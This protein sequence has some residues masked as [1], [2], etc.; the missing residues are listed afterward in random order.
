MLKFVTILFIAGI[1]VLSANSQ[2]PKAP[3]YSKKSSWL[4]LEK[5]PQ[6]AFD[7]FY[8]HPTTYKDLKDGKNASIDNVKANQ[9][10]QDAFNRQATAFKK[11]CNI[12]AP[13]YRQVSRK[14]LGGFGLEIANKCLEYAT[15]DMHKAFEYYL[16][17]YNNGRPF[18]L[19]SHSQGTGVTMEFL[20]KYGSIVDK[21][22]LVAA[23]LIG[24]AITPED[25]KQMGLKLAVTPEQLCGVLVWNTISKGGKA[26]TSA[27]GALCINPLCWTASQKE[28]PNTK[29]IY[30]RIYFSSQKIV[31]IP[32]YT[33]AKADKNGNLVIPVPYNNKELPMALGPR[34][35]HQY[36]YDFF[37]GNIVENAAVRCKAW[38]KKYSSK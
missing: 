29:N 17:H 3:D 33:S 21:K 27:P 11:S 23:Y 35:Y 24:M 30:A 38:L 36:D 37:Y 19:A 28:Q 9:G 20:K 12:F 34:V 6:K 16:K 5:K 18:I 4:H 26:P 13:R 1:C 15:A 25:L 8:M 7:V 14:V 10:A 2:V 22:K 31:T 32:N